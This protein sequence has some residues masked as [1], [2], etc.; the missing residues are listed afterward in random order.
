VRS[1]LRAVPATVPDPFLN[2]NEES[3]DGYRSGM[4]LGLVAGILTLST[5]GCAWFRQPAPSPL[6]TVLS[7]APTLDEVIST[8]NGNSSRI[9]SFSTNHAE[10]SGPELPI[11]LRGVNIAFERPKRLRMRARSLAGPELDLGSNDELFWIWVARNEPPAVYFCRHDQFAT[12][13]AARSL[14]IDP[15]WLIEAMGIVEFRPDEEHLGPYR[16]SAGIL[17]IHS[18]RHT[19]D[20]PAKKITTVHASTGAVLKQQVYNHLGELVAIATAH[21]H[22]RDPLSGLL[23]PRIVDIESPM[24]QF[25]LRVNLG[26]VAINT[27]MPNAAEFW[28]MPRIEG[29]QTVD[30]GDPRLQFLPNPPPT[31]RSAALSHPRTAVRARNRLMK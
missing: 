30:I 11:T 6:P 20:G 23:M 4:A 17:E 12:S 25:S 13:N 27:P 31:G 22:R 3:M 18:T 19:P 10:L 1:T 5:S 2:H 15:D 24:A 14:P 28:T 29:F 21:E 7:Q 8:V 26:D 9:Q 16:T